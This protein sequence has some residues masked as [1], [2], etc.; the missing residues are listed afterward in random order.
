MEPPWKVL[1]LPPA[2][3]AP[4][5]TGGSSGGEEGA[6]EKADVDLSRKRRGWL[7]WLRLYAIVQSLALI[8]ATLMPPAPGAP[9]GAAIFATVFLR[10]IIP[11]AAAVLLS[12]A[13]APRRRR[14]KFKLTPGSP[15][16]HFQAIELVAPGPCRNI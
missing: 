9:P 1:N 16:P 7:G 3:C 13:L 14:A 6:F 15:T 2:C 10:T 12:T 8:A 4:P 5:P 11:A